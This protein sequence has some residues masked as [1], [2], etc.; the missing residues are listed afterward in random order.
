MSETRNAEYRVYPVRGMVLFTA[1]L[2]SLSSNALWISYSAVADV[3]TQYFDKTVNEIDLLATISFIVGIPM[4][5]VSTY[6]VDVVGFRAGILLSSFLTFFGGLV[7]CLSTLPCI[8]TS[9]SLDTQF[10][11]SVFAQALTGMGN[12]L[13]V[14]LPTKISQ[15]WFP[16]TERTLATGILAMALPLGIVFGQGCSPL[17]VKGP[18]DIPIL[19][20]VG[21][22]PAAVTL[23]LCLFTVKSSLPPTPP[24]RSAEIEEQRERK[25]FRDYLANMKA[26]MTNR[27]F[28]ILFATIGGAVGFFNA[29]LTQLSQLMCSRGYGNVFSGVCASLTLAMGLFGAIG[30][31]V[32]VEKFGKIMEIAKIFNFIAALFGVLVAVFMTMSNQNAFLATFCTL[33]GVFGFG[34]YPMALELS[35][36]AT[37]PIDESIGTALIFLSGQ[38][39]GGILIFLSEMLEQELDKDSFHVEVCSSFLSANSSDLVLT[40]P[41]V[42]TQPTSAIQK[43]MD[44][45]TT[46]SGAADH[47]HFLI[48][49]AVYISALS[50]VFVVFFRTEY[51]RTKANDTEENVKEGKDN[52][53]LELEVSGI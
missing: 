20:I 10:W 38:L 3:S 32:M 23:L 24:S 16:E 1:T 2:L 21:F 17:F 45:P 31:G 49:L 47:T 12:P 22:I 52:L 43:T 19:N 37:Y 8:N 53:G 13:A 11:L 51:K 28:L 33:F 42:T 15:N 26:V 48:V 39:Q 6:V 18:E 5:L 14:S 4:C 35:V 25:A 7:R 34:M 46:T 27:P 44:T 29:F 41:T 9:L 36:E 30:A 40:T 50:L